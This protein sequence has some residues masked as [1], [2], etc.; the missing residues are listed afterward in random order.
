MDKKII[1][2]NP[3]KFRLEKSTSSF[4]FPHFID[5]EKKEVWIY[6]AS[7]FPST[8]AVP[9]LMKIHYPHYKSCLCNR[10][11]FIRIGGKL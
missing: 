8:L 9:H 5:E 4:R 11:T 6:I 7:G 10:E 1:N 2:K 3:R